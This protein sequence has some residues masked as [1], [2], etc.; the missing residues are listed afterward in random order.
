MRAN[1]LVIS[2]VVVLLAACG[3]DPVT[4]GG[5]GGGSAPMSASINGTQ[6][7]AS[8]AT[9]VRAG[10]GLYSI[11]G[12]RTATPNYT[13]IFQLYNIGSTGSYALGVG[14]Q[15]FGGSAI[16]SSPTLGSWSTP[17]DG[18]AGTITINTLTA[19]RIAGTFAYTTDSQGNPP[20]P[21]SVTSGTFDV[22]VTG[23]ASALPDNAG[24]KLTATI[25]GNAFVASAAGVTLSGATP[26]LQ[27]V[28]NDF[29]RSLSIGILNMTAAGTYP[30][31]NTPSRTVQYS[32]TVS[33]VF[34]TWGSQGT[35]GS[36]TVIVTSVTATRIIGTFTATLTPVSGAAGGSLTVSGSFDMGR[37]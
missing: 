3:S 13:M 32:A 21:L 16:V 9:A 8:T 12:I 5:G 33:N 10:P 22:P 19:T 24:S 7:S 37:L 1:A 26:Y 29:N 2:A 11:T 17:L 23:S 31:G 14:P 30:L 35:G 15:I 34:S 27:I 6:W 28:G 20:T 36:G 18:T 4:P 25:N